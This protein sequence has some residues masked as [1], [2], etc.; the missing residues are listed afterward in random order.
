MNIKRWMATATIAVGASAMAPL[1]A[2]AW[3]SEPDEP[4]CSGDFQPAECGPDWD[5][6]NPPP[7]Q[8]DSFGTDRDL[9]RA[10]DE[11]EDGVHCAGYDVV[12]V[13]LTRNATTLVWT[14]RLTYSC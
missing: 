4:I 13:R 5:D 9:D 12:R 8:Y 14:Y 7:P 1:T 2:N 11:A 3:P 10:Q 6:Y